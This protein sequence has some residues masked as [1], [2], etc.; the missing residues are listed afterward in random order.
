MNGRRNLRFCEKQW[1]K[2]NH[3]LVPFFVSQWIIVYV[4]ATMCDGLRCPLSFQFS[5]TVS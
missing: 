5:E 3:F 1:N 4:M 2:S